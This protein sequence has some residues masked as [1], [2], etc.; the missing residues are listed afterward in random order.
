MKVLCLNSSNKPKNIPDNEW[1]E[2]GK[3]Y[4]VIN[5]VQMGIQAGKLGYQLEEVSLSEKSFPYEY[6]DAN[7]FAICENSTLIETEIVKETEEF[8]I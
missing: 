1:I 3:E 8:T 4:T 7:R 2:K 6:Y 5:V